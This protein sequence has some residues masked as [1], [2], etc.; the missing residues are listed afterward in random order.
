MDDPADRR[1][2]RPLSPEQEQ[3]FRST[4]AKYEAAYRNTGERRALMNAIAHVWWAQQT[5]PRWLVPAIGEFIAKSQ[6][7]D[8]AERFRERMRHVRRY[9]CVRDLR[10]I[11]A[12]EGGR[13]KWK[14]T[15]DEALD[16][17]VGM[18]KGASAVRVAVDD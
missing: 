14:Y 17:A 10:S 5:L 1:P 18:L 3:E 9:T 12:A 7:D 11:P 13:R 8:E 16:L 4:Q 15:K 6:T 2:F